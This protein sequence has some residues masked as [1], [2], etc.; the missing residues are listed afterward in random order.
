MGFREG[1]GRFRPVSLVV[2]DVRK[3]NLIIIIII[4]KMQK[5]NDLKKN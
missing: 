5:R 2:P 4:P 3:K 1:E